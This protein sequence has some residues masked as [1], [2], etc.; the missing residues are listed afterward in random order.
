LD[1]FLGRLLILVWD[2]LSAIQFYLPVE[3][4]YFSSLNNHPFLGVI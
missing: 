3:V 1:F 2:C 4:T